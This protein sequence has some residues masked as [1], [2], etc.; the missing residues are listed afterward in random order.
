[1]PAEIGKLAPDFRLP[2]QNDILVSRAD[3]LGKKAL[4]LFF[5]FPFT[6]VCEGELRA[7]QDD[8]ARF[9]DLGA[10]V[11]A[12][13]TTPRPAIRAW[14]EQQGFEFPILSDFWPH[15]E[16]ARAYGVLNEDN[17]APYRYSFI[18]DPDGIVRYVVR[19][20]YLTE[21]RQHEEYAEALAQL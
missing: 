3:L 12:I 13:T 1:M 10:K 2:D 20:D 16:V 14:A 6:R 15:G 7:V 17:G 11:V 19:S 8:Y 18:L 21:G 5:P 9:L 4:V